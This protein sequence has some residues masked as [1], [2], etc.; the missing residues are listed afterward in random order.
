MLLIF[1]IS[2][3]ELLGLMAYKIIISISLTCTAIILNIFDTEEKVSNTVD[4]SEL[5]F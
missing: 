2:K 1:L 4:S 5:K 3:S